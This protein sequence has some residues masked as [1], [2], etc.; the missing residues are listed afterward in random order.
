MW[1]DMFIQRDHPTLGRLS[2]ANSVSP[3][4]SHL[5]LNTLPKDT[6]IA[7]W[8]YSETQEWP[9]P[10]YFHDK[11]YP[12]VV[13]PWKTKLN[14]VSLLNTAKKLELFGVM[15]TTWDSLDVSL[16]TVAESGVLAWTVPDFRLDQIPF[17]HWLSAIRQYAIRDLPELETT[18][19]PTFPEQ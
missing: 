16:P 3:V 9:V 4:N 17:D 19:T 10:Q 12:V 11:G 5:A 1:H 2:P 8:N 15:Q 14:A 6:I 18:L 7:A 13:C